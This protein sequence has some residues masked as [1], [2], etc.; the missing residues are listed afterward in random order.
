[1]EELNDR[2]M[3]TFGA[4]L[5]PLDMTVSNIIVHD[6][7]GESFANEL[8]IAVHYSIEGLFEPQ[9]VKSFKALQKYT[10]A[11]KNGGWDETLRTWP[12][13]AGDSSI[14]LSFVDQSAPNQLH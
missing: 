7:L 1:M 2:L 6:L 5:A 8:D 4:P 9:K 3:S 13:L 12:C 10:E 14:T 11:H